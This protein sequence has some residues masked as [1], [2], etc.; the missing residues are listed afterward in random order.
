MPSRS[1]ANGS[2][3]PCPAR[4]AQQP[5]R[6]PPLVRRLS[7]R[8][9]FL[10]PSQHPSTPI[11]LGRDVCPRITCRRWD[12]SRTMYVWDC[13]KQPEICKHGAPGSL[14]SRAWSSAALT[15]PHPRKA[16]PADDQERPSLRTT[17]AAC[18]S[19]TPSVAQKVRSFFA[20][21]L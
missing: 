2:L 17:N 11:A 7:L 1:K 9:A 10:S 5:D 18:P 14:I 19:S 21:R 16:T 20:S 15:H 6:R 12:P 3:P 13:G 8:R 4:K